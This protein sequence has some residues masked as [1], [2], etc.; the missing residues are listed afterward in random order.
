MPKV[1]ADLEVSAGCRASA[2]PRLQCSSAWLSSGGFVLPFPPG[3]PECGLNGIGRTQ[4]GTV[5]ASPS[6]PDP[7]RDQEKPGDGPRAPHVP[8][9]LPSPPAG[10]CHPE[11]D[12]ISGA[13]HRR[14]AGAAGH[15]A[16]GGGG[17]TGGGGGLQRGL[18]D[19]GR[20]HHC[21]AT[22]EEGWG[23]AGREGSG[24][25]P[26]AGPGPGQQASRCFPGAGQ[27]GDWVC[28]AGEGVLG[29]LGLLIPEWE[30]PGE[31]GDVP[32]RAPACWADVSYVF[33]S[34]LPSFSPGCLPSR[35]S[36][37][38]EKNL[39]CSAFSS[40]SCP[41]AP[42]SQRRLL[43]QLFSPSQPAHPLH[44]AALS[45]P[46]W[47][48]WGPGR[49]GGPTTGGCAGLHPSLSCASHLEVRGLPD[50]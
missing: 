8:G 50:R 14:A 32:L 45:N 38:S 46:L 37:P 19:R 36:H 23:A 34:L 6:P 22:R 27:R 4:N 5:T 16:G 3:A 41:F 13:A 47:F 21:A 40:S 18:D 15:P 11:Q 39:P 42:A 9:A 33:I 35:L 10:P 1:I 2:Q 48:P 17:S 28:V 26:R 25:A 30:G 12:P 43:Q 7:L 44:P 29:S 49:W 20:R 31:P 24:S